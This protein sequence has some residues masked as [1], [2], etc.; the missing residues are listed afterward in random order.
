MKTFDHELTS[1]SLLRSVW[2][3][4]WPAILLNLINGL[5]PLIN[6][7][8]IGHY[9]QADNNAANAAVGVAWQVFL[10][11]VVFVSSVFHG[12]N[13][14]VSQAAGRRDREMLS[15]VVY[16]SFLASMYLLPLIVAPLG[17]L[18]APMD[19]AWHADAGGGDGLRAAVPAG[20]LRGLH[21]DVP[22]V[23]VHERVSVFG[24]AKAGAGAGRVDGGGEPDH[25]RAAHHGRWPRAGDGRDGRGGGQCDCAVDHGNDRDLLHLARQDPH[26]APAAADPQARFCP[27]A[28]DHG[29]WRALG[30]P[31]RGAEHR[32][33]MPDHLHQRAERDCGAGGVHHLLS[34]HL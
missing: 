9:V 16:Q 15:R 1:G 30:H 17:I 7:I 24:R 32:R 8:L 3:I 22:D 23:H 21:A 33:G 29:D 28:H 4:A 25:Q 26:P 11:V 12:M 6:Q 31:G 27:A 34:V 10:V 13:V 19:A 2:K 5:P 20:A 18:L 14:L